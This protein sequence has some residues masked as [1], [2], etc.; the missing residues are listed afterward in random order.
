M[1]KLNE[2]VK[3][4]MSDFGFSRAEAKNYI[5]QIEGGV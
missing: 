1:D 3:I 2:R 4:I 5:N